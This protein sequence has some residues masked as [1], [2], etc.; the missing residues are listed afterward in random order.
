MI[1]MKNKNGLW[2]YIDSLWLAVGE[3][4]VALLVFL[5]FLIAKAAGAEVTLYKAVTGALLGG[6]VT[7]IN[8]LILSVA[9]NRAV[10]GYITERGDKQ[11][12]EEEAEK[13]AKEHGMAVQNAMTKSYLFRMALMIGA[14]VLAMLSGWFNPLATVIPLLCFQPILII[15]QSLKNKR[16]G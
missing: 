10:N 2:V 1:K 8:F 7:V 6:A 11:M 5:G 14:L 13:Y 4:A 9:V 16:R 15:S 12:D 3:L